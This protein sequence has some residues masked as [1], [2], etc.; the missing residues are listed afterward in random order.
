[1]R[2]VDLM[3]CGGRFSEEK[4]DGGTEDGEDRTAG[5]VVDHRFCVVS[6]VRRGDVHGSSV[7]AL[8]DLW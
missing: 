6:W 8:C 4:W 5:R 1:M 2:L 7:S 3:A